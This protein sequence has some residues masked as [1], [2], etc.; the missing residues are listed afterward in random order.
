ME[1]ENRLIEL[2]KKHD[3]EFELWDAIIDK[4]TVVESISASHKMIVQYAKDNGLS[5]ICIAEQDLY[6]TCLG[7]WEYFISNKPAEYSIYIGGNYLINDPDKYEPP[8]V[9]VKEYVG[10]QLIVV[11]EKYY[12][13]FLSVPDNAHIDVAQ[14]GLG[15]FYVCFPMVALQRPGFSAN[16]QT[17]VNYNTILKPEWIYNGAVHNL[18]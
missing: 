2:F 18:P 3:I 14:R 13:T 10:N 8:L 6:F 15:D 4:K 17:K 11:A 7:A 5:E 9:K 16:A 12:D 1:D